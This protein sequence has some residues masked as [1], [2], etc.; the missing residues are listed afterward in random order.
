MMDHAASS[1]GW[2]EKQRAVE[3]RPPGWEDGFREEPV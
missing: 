1:G 3:K 2:G